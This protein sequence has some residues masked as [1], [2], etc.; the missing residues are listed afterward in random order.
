MPAYKLWLLLFNIILN[1]VLWPHHFSQMQNKT[2]YLNTSTIFLLWKKGFLI[3]L[4]IS[5]VSF[6]CSPFCVSLCFGNNSRLKKIHREDIASLYIF[7]KVMAVWR[8]T[9]LWVYS[10]FLP[11]LHSLH[12]QTLTRTAVQ[13][14][15]YFCRADVSVSCWVL[16]SSVRM[17]TRILFNSYLPFL[18]HIY[19][20]WQNFKFS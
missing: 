17:K 12:S 6:Q 15:W 9:A 20:Q 3:F 1:F 8:N 10:F 18:S 11:H 16:V 5:L 13:N 4:W 2:V 19:C 7:E 14:C